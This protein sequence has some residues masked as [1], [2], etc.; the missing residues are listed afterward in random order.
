MAEACVSRTHRQHPRC[1]PPVLK[2]GTITGPH[3]LPRFGKNLQKLPP[4]LAKRLREKNRI[5]IREDPGEVRRENTPWPT[6][7]ELLRLRHHS[8]IGFQSLPAAGIFL[9]R[10]VFCNRSWDDHVL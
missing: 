7:H 5:R 10:L 2:T 4:E 8:Q 1:R 6:L 9:F 3:A